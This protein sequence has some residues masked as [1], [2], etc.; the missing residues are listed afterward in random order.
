MKCKIVAEA[1]YDY[2]AQTDEDLTFKD[3]AVLLVI[4]DSDE[5]WW[6]CKERVN[7]AFSDG[8]EGLAPAAYIQELDPKVV[9]TA[10]YDYTART[11]EEVTM[12]QGAK[13]LVYENEDPEWWFV[14]ID[15][16]AGL[17]PA[18]YLTTENSSDVPAAPA[19][20]AP[21]VEV[22]IAQKKSLILTLDKFGGPAPKT[23]K[24]L[25]P[26]RPPDTLKLIKVMEVDKKKKKNSKLV[27]IGVDDEY[28]IYICDEYE[29]VQ[30]KRE[31]KEL[32]KFSEKKGKKVTMEFGSDTREYEGEKDDLERLHKRL[33]EISIRS[34]VSGPIITGP[35]PNIGPP[36]GS[37]TG[38]PTAPATTPFTPPALVPPVVPAPPVTQSPA[39]ASSR[40]VVALYDYLATNEEE[41]TISEGDTLVLLDDSD[42]EWWKVRFVKKGGAEGLVPALYV[43]LKQPGAPSRDDGE[44]ERQRLEEERR[45]RERMERER[46]EAD[47]RARE[48]AAR[49]ERR[50]AAMEA[51][52][53]RY[54]EESRKAALAAVAA[55]PE[56]PT[57]PPATQT[58]PPSA[59]VPRAVPE[60]TAKQPTSGNSIPTA[61]PRIPTARPN[62]Q[63]GGRPKSGTE[64]K[65]VEKPNEANLRSWNDRS[66]NYQVQAEFLSVVEGKVHLHK[67][68]GVKIQV[69]LE[70]LCAAD[71]DFIRSIPGYENISSPKGNGSAPVKPKF[72]A[73]A[74]AA[75]LSAR[76]AA[77]APPP[78][79]VIYNGPL[80]TKKMDRSILGDIDRE[81]LKALNI[82]EGD[83]IRIRKYAG[84]TVGGSPAFG[85]VDKEKQALFQ[86]R[87]PAS[88]GRDNSNLTPEEQLR[89]D[90]QYARELQQQELQGSA[91][92][93][94]A[95]LKGGSRR[96][97]KQT[98]NITPQSIL[99]MKDALSGSPTSSPLMP[100]SSSASSV[101][102]AQTNAKPSSDPWSIPTESRTAAAP[103]TSSTSSHEAELKKQQL[104]QQQKAQVAMTAQYQSLQAERQSLTA[105]KEAAEKEKA[106]ALAA[107]RQVEQEAAQLQA[108]LQAQKL[109]AE[110]EVAR[111][112]AELE[113]Q[114]KQFELQKQE[115]EKASALK[116]MKGET[117]RLEAQ[118]AE[119][120][121]LAALRPMQAPLIPT[122]STKPSSSFV[123]VSSA[124]NAA[125]GSMI[126]PSMGTVGA[127]ALVPSS[128][129]G[130]GGLSSGIGAGALVPAGFAHSGLLQQPQQPTAIDPNDKY[131]VFK[132]VNPSAPSVFTGAPPSVL[133]S[134]TPVSNLGLF[135][136][137]PA[138]FGNPALGLANGSPGLVGLPHSGSAMPGSMGVQPGGAGAF[139]ANP[140]AGLSGLA[141]PSPAAFGSVFPAG[142]IG[143]IGSLGVGGLNSA[144]TPGL[145][146]G[147]STGLNPGMGTGL[148]GGLGSSL[149]GPGTPSTAFGGLSVNPVMG[150]GLMGPTAAPFGGLGGG[151]GNVNQP[152]GFPN[153][154]SGLS[155][156]A[157]MQ[158][159]QPGLGTPQSATLFPGQPLQSQFGGR[160][161]F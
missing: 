159:L 145:N 12:M 139:G 131:S 36:P 4:D 160:N 158:S 156:M 52:K 56:L 125:L 68:N 151:L 78:A 62:S 106:A 54:A 5:D 46:A 42:S 84:N 146:T 31:F 94:S 122:P 112:Q 92:A 141:T 65:I 105:A 135:S 93:T 117:A 38:V 17:V 80:S 39:A 126:T 85:N 14:R 43:E 10:L 98:N 157:G 128:G 28:M 75:T 9:A 59:P 66:G 32:T 60:T 70:K 45:D 16:E 37:L 41:L 123:P 61:I 152:T 107:R 77:T 24:G 127:G 82:S 3:G 130:S 113:R 79:T 47:R 90:E 129:I 58:A 1:L 30:E 87:A 13:V 86:S 96:Q 99:A 34:K 21:P 81:T 140:L 147:L 25:T 134:S 19:E 2:D 118:L 108:K 11:D 18:S 148:G 53:Q 115:A 49:E 109:A 119:Q 63:A 88:F 55:K 20:A 67:V 27:Y 35:L 103:A 149:S 76:L 161:G 69:P 8:K 44:E 83:I 133:G 153:S 120:K 124:G 6:T 71:L 50:I 104:L 132:T 121:R 95:L 22:A 15:N 137:N 116:A 73:A 23:T 102:R 150:S 136:A 74:T 111:R 33:E 91:G 100:R 101:P 57:R 114:R 26:V 7:D 138:P 155:T 48:A 51:E 142:G 40:I 89:L 154:P 72:D 143:G 97:G 144:F 64:A 29:N 110:Q